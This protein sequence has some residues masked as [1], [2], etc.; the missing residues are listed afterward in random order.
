MDW[1]E[2]EVKA[3]YG[4]VRPV[5]GLVERFRRGE[6]DAVRDFEKAA[7]VGDDADSFARF[8]AKA[9][10]WLAGRYVGDDPS[11]LEDRPQARRTTSGRPDHRSQ[12]RRPPLV[13]GTLVRYGPNRAPYVQ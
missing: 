8:S 1:Y 7:T 5:R 4:A 3:A 10:L 2:A 13:V 6:P 12:I 11:R 9:K